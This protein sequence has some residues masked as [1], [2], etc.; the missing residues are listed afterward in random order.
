MPD[1]NGIAIAGESDWQAI[2]D[3]RGTAVASAES[4]DNAK[5]FWHK[6]LT[7]EQPTFAS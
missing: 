3:A 1:D 2:L 6:R 4:M 7:P 5:P